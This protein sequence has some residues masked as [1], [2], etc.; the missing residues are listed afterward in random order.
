[1][2]LL[3]IKHEAFM[4]ITLGTILF[5]LGLLYRVT[6]LRKN[7]IFSYVFFIFSISTAFICR[8]IA[9]TMEPQ[10]FLISAAIPVCILVV[11]LWLETDNS[12]DKK[13]AEDAP[14]TL[15]PT[16][17]KCRLSTKN[18]DLLGQAPASQSG[19]D[20]RKEQMMSILAPEKYSMALLNSLGDNIATIERACVN[21]ARENNKPG[22]LLVALE[23]VLHSNNLKLAFDPIAPSNRH[24][25]SKMLK[26]CDKTGILEISDRATMP[27]DKPGGYFHAIKEQKIVE[28]KR[29]EISTNLDEKKQTDLENQPKNTEG[30]NTQ[31]PEQQTSDVTQSDDPAVNTET[32][33]QNQ[34]LE[35]MAHALPTQQF[36]RQHFE[37]V[38]Q[39]ITA[40]DTED[41]SSEEMIFE[42]DE[43]ETTADDTKDESEN[44]YLDE[45]VERLFPQASP[46]P[47]PSQ[48]QLTVQQENTPLTI[49]V[50]GEDDERL[51]ATHNNDQ[52][53][54]NAIRMDGDEMSKKVAQTKNQKETSD[55]IQVEQFT[56]S[57][58]KVTTETGETKVVIQIDKGVKIANS[59]K[60]MNSQDDDDEGTIIEKVNPDDLAGSCSEI[61]IEIPED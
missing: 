29:Q 56:P 3:Q 23:R 21:K 48:P 9:R 44:M 43:Q 39:E 57:K 20:Y 18:T 31:V 11:I 16:V 17:Y 59:T 35:R 6:K 50:G 24:G 55:T 40:G 1:M 61:A 49:D 12:N 32:P 54:D 47:T 51:Y 4:V 5:C 27:K 36:T 52:N 28:N 34:K 45:D 37:N 25:D 60:G 41:E 19:R 13:V 53:F 38:K 46:Y 15:V 30:E 2:F 42:E 14:A 26:A 7:Y 22:N 10:P 33:V 8:N 58:R